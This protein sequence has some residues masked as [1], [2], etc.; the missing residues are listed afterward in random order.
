M[1]SHNVFVTLGASNHTEGERHPDDYY[2]TEPKATELLMQE[3]DFSECVL[4]PCCGQG[5]M[6][7]VLAR[8]YKVYAFDLFDRGYGTVAD[9]FKFKSW[10]G[11]IITNPPYKGAL[12][13]VQHAL[14]IIPEGNKVAMFLRIQFL[15]GKERGEFFKNNPPK[16]IY[17]SR[18]RLKCGKNGDFGSL[19]SS[20]TA[21]AWFVWQKGFKGEPIIRWIN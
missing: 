3:Q 12:K 5:H 13:F 6:A 2:A 19:S 20:A 18:G 14:E 17:I 21:Y 7:E 8:K 9:F 1:S 4:E 11:D 15:E 16:Y 10:H